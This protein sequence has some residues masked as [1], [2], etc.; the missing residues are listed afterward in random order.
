MATVRATLDGPAPSGVPR[1]YGAWAA[2]VLRVLGERIR[3]S[4]DVATGQ[5]LPMLGAIDDVH[6]RIDVAG[7]QR[8]ADVFVD[9]VMALHGDQ[10]RRDLRASCGRKT[11]PQVREYVGRFV[12]DYRSRVAA[13]AAL[14]PAQEAIWAAAA[15]E[16]ARRAWSC[17][18]SGASE[19]RTLS[20]L[21]M[22]AYFRSC[23]LKT[24]A[25]VHGNLA[26]LNGSRLFVRGAFTRIV[27]DVSTSGAL[28]PRPALLGSGV[29]AFAPAL[30]FRESQTSVVASEVNAIA[31]GAGVMHRFVS[32]TA[33]YSRGSAILTPTIS[34]VHLRSEVY[35]QY[36]YS[37]LAHLALASVEQVLRSWAQRAGVVHIKAT[38]APRGVFSWAHALPMSAAALDAVRLL[39]DPA[40]GALRNRIAHSSLIDIDCKRYERILVLTT[41]AT[42]LLPGGDPFLPEN[43]AALCVDAL[44]KVERDAFGAGVTSAHYGWMQ[45]LAPDAAS[46]GF[47]SAL[48][49]GLDGPAPQAWLDQMRRFLAC[50]C[51]TLGR[52]FSLGMIAW[53]DR[54]APSSLT[55]LTPLVLSFEAVC[56]IVVQVLG[57]RSLQIDVGPNGLRAQYTMLDENGLVSPELVASVVSVVPTAAGRANAERCF[58][59]ATT[60]RNSFVHG[61]LGGISA[62]QVAASA[63]AIVATVDLLVARATHHM[64]REAAYFRSLSRSHHSTERPE[65]LWADAEREVIRALDV[66]ASGR[67]SLP[68]IDDVVLA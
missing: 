27:Q 30:T 22:A 16:Y 20:E 31:R 8:T 26:S 34:L 37:A 12:D 41:G 45:Q 63:K 1:W 54:G 62:A 3:A 17:A 53:I 14:F 64:I 39:Y 56:R 57:F 32:P 24:A 44:T 55:E 40:C 47:A 10:L 15:D 5:V 58:H 38:G 59:L 51:P 6:L 49:T 42:R 36:E 61:A 11:G 66:E 33:T 46:Y 48:R 68:G 13:N 9:E 23:R 19:W 4:C 50:F 18:A 67:R 29:P 28:D 2:A 7:S 25:D 52:I 60:V 21:L 65:H 35:R 43:V